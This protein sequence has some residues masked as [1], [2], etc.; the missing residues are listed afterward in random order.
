[1]F[2]G[3]LVLSRPGGDEIGGEQNGVGGVYG[4]YGVY[5]GV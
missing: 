5:S 4:V 1:M 3:L 2:G